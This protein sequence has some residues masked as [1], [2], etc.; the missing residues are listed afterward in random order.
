MAY[1]RRVTIAGTTL[2]GHT[3]EVDVDSEGH[4]E[5]VVVRPSTAFGQVSVAEETPVVQIDGTEGVLTTDVETFTATGGGATA[6]DGMFVCTTGT[7][8]GGYGVVRSRRD[9]RYRAG[10]GYMA[11]FTA[12][13]TAGV[14][15]SLQ[16]AGLFTS[17]NSLCFGYN[18]TSF[19]I[20]RGTEGALEIR[21]LTVTV[22]AGGAETG[23][24]T[25]AG[26][27]TNVSL[28]SGSTTATAAKIG[29]DSFAGWSAFQVGATVV[30]VAT[31]VGAKSGTFSFSSTGT[32]A[33]TFAA[34]RA[35]AVV[36]ETWTAQ[37]DWNVDK[38]DGT[39]PSGMT[40][41]TTKLNVYKIQMQWLGAGNIDFYV[42]DPGEG[43][44][45]LV[46]R[47]K[48]ANANTKPSIRNPTMKLGWAA[49]SLGSTTNLTVKGASGYVAVEG[50]RVH[51]RNPFSATA[52]KGGISS[53]VPVLSIRNGKTF[54]GRI[55]FREV[56]PL[57]ASVGTDGSGSAPVTVYFYM[58]A[59]LTGA[60]WL[61]AWNESCV[62]YDTSATALS[63]GTYLTVQ[64][65][66]KNGQ[67]VI[68]LKS[69]DIVVSSDD[70]VT[71]VV[72]TSAG[73]VTAAVSIAWDE[74]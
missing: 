38:M 30:F 47:I 52:T 21:T 16:Q 9:G 49:A 64:A 34:T 17:E 29:A 70:V 19:G 61:S 25:L 14:A 60:Q 55:N 8:V 42:E 37:S 13:F 71:I 4:F 63:G 11:R 69:M 28:S 58:N 73:T 3:E 67:A 26:V 51:V 6:S 54:G 46:H 5:T 41:D 40:L 45:A 39:G 50:R 53:A 44:F 27:A 18:G 57:R 59:T 74:E 15:S 48:Y 31:A 24:V 62:H 65:L 7:S 35:G 10:Q 68:D 20:L 2:G 43:Q 66:A 12:M 32:A 56:L 36:T 1:I 72:G 22:G 23:T 33:G